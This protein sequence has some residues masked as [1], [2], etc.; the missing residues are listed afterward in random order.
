[1]A[2]N[3]DLPVVA[4]DRLDI[5]G[6]VRDGAVAS[7]L[8]IGQVRRLDTAEAWLLLEL[9]RR[10]GSSDHPVTPAGRQQRADADCR[11]GAP[12]SGDRGRD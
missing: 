12:K 9:Q 8:D 5:E 1:M 3:G 7:A 11:D 4:I 6:I 2:F 10:L